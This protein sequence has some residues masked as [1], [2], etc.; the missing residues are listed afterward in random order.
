MVE[1]VLVDRRFR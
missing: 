1:F